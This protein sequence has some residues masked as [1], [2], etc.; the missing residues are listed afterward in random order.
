MA[1]KTKKHKWEPRRLL[2]GKLTGMCK[3]CG[4]FPEHPNHK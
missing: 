4:E 2:N 1:I 3:H